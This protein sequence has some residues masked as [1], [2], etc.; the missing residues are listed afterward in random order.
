[1]PSKHL[2]KRGQ[3]LLDTSDFDPAIM[4]D[5]DMQ[6]HVLHIDN[7]RACT[8]DKASWAT[9]QILRQAEQRARNGHNLMGAIWG[10]P[11]TSRHDCPALGLAAGGARPGGSPPAAARAPHRCAPL[12]QPSPCAWALVHGRP[13]SAAQ[14]RRRR[15][16]VKPP[17]ELPGL[18][19]RKAARAV[20]AGMLALYPG[21][22]PNEKRHSIH[23]IFADNSACLMVLWHNSV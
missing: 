3:V 2:L 13:S 10:S 5:I 16:S 15:T 21:L 4:C 23:T 19:G 14:V 8:L 20:L 7:A 12:G 9:V 1:M 17:G 18:M 22:S 6:C 11:W